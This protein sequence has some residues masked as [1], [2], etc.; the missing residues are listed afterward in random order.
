LVVATSDVRVTAGSDAGDDVRALDEMLF[1]DDGLT[2]ARAWCHEP[3]LRLATAAA[4][5]VVERTLVHDRVRVVD[6]GS[7]SG[8]GAKYLVSCLAARGFDPRDIGGRVELIV[9]DL[10]G[11]WFAAVD[12]LD[13]LGVT[14]VRAEL[15]D[16][17]GPILTLDEVLG[18]GSVDVVM[19]SMVL[20]LIPPPALS[21]SLAGIHRSLR[22][23]GAWLWTSPD[24]S[25][26]AEG[27]VLAHDLNREV[28]RL[29]RTLRAGGRPDLSA[30]TIDEGGRLLELVDRCAEPSD[31]SE[32]AA[33]RQIPNPA[34]TV[35]DIQ[36]AHAGLFRGDMRPS[37]ST[38]SD[39]DLL[40]LALV[41]SNLKNIGEL[42]DR[43]LCAEL[44]ELLARAALPG[45]H[46][47]VRSPAP[48]FPLSW[49][50][51]EYRA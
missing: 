16:G 40:R 23:G 46:A 7:G 39:D 26:A 30:L 35:T 21:K 49:V 27:A 10:P 25:P 31:G 29:F 48:T 6:Y 15:R 18:D 50:H 9:A 32:L 33:R 12:R 1:V 14:A 51:G 44:V 43:Q 13:A 24:S 47:A 36:S 3:T 38:V 5:A 42:A 19:A 34:T 17:D 22:P 41:P 45:L 4:A 28:R 20:H 11:P 37:T 2:Q 8:L